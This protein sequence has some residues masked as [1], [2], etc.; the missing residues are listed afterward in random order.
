VQWSH[1]GENNLFVEVI[2]VRKLT[3]VFIFLIRSEFK[4]DDF[5]EAFDIM[6]SGL[7][8]KVILDWDWDW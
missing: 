1:I 5:Q 6:E 4:I 8:S 2:R 7:A 3:S